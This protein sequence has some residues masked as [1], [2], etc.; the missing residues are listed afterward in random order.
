MTHPA[1]T[2]DAAA[3]ENKRSI[4]ATVRAKA[5]NRMTFSSRHTARPLQR[6]GTTI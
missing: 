2:A 6:Y 3:A 5:V 4:A 1:V